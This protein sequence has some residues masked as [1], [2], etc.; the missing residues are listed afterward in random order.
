M[1]NPSSKTKSERTFLKLHFLLLVIYNF[2]YMR[3]NSRVEHRFFLRYTKT[4][5]TC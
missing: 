4:N 5:N 2:N 1:K 3:L